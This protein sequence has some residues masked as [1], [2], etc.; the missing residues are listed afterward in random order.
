MLNRA[1]ALTPG[2]LDELPRVLSKKTTGVNLHLNTRS[3]IYEGFNAT[4]LPKQMAQ[5]LSYYREGM[6]YFDLMRTYV[7]DYMRANGYTESDTT[8]NRTT[9]DSCGADAELQAFVHGLGTAV[10]HFKTPNF[11]KNAQVGSPG[12]LTCTKL[13]DF[14][15]GTFYDVSAYHNVVGTLGSENADPCFAPYALVEGE[16]C[17]PPQ[18][19]F[20]QRLTVLLTGLYQAEIFESDDHLF[21]S[22]ASKQ[23]EADFV[24]SMLNFSKSLPSR[25]D[26]ITFQPQ[27][28]ATGDLIVPTRYHGQYKHRHFGIETSIGI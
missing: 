3:T 2:G 9:L 22:D 14:L 10:S 18:A 25:P 16:T 20:A 13:I 26:Y 28:E 17:P 15:A 1:T 24:Q 21:I 7:V 27:Q 6:A 11:V 8:T 19:A 12:E 4:G 23:V 5:E